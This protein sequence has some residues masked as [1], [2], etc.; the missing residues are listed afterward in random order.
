MS[1]CL[2]V[3]QLEEIVPLPFMRRLHVNLG[4]LGLSP[5]EVH[6]RVVP[7][8]RASHQLEWWRKR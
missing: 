6:Q 5:E 2:A 8:V 3:E 1:S 4:A 7:F